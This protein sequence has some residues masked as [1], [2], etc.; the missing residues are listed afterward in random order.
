M[1]AKLARS[2]AYSLEETEEFIDRTTRINSIQGIDIPDQRVTGADKDTEV[3]VEIFNEINSNGT[4]LSSG[5]LVLARISSYWP[6]ARDEMMRRLQQWK[7]L[8]LKVD[9]DTLLR[10]VAAVV[11]GSYNHEDLPKRTILEIQSALSLTATAINVLLDTTKM[12]LGMDPGK[13]DNTKQAFPI[14]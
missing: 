4:K 11:D 7:S 6:D 13:I 14:W 3:V 9:H 10:C 2:G 5:D 1:I 12:Y 8:R